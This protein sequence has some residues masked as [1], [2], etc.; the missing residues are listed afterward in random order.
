MSQ[1][2]RFRQADPQFPGEFAEVVVALAHVVRLERV[3]FGESG[4]PGFEQ[5]VDMHDLRGKA[6]LARGRRGL[7]LAVD[8]VAGQ[9]QGVDG[10]RPLFHAWPPVSPSRTP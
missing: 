7:D 10:G 6:R 1:F 3:Y 5:V 2:I 4:A 9:D 8:A